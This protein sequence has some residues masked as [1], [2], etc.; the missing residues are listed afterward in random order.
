MNY[1][2]PITQNVEKFQPF[3]GVKNNSLVYPTNVYLKK[4]YPNLPYDMVKI[5]G[6]DGRN[7]FVRLSSVKHINTMDV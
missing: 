5:P 1:H 3:L 7:H 4:Q 6:M 2:T